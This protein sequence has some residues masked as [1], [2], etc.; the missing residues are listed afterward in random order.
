MTD[1]LWRRLYPSRTEA[2][3]AETPGKR[4]LFNLNYPKPVIDFCSIP[5]AILSKF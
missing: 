5:A 1:K 3:S 2:P 4:L